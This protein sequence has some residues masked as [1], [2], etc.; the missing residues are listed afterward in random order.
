[1]WIRGAR[2]RVRAVGSH[3]RGVY[4]DL[5]IGGSGAVAETLAVPAGVNY[6]GLPLPELSGRL[7]TYDRDHSTPAS[8]LSPRY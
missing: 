5:P 7:Q 8:P 2:P 6:N 1:M 3:A 4:L